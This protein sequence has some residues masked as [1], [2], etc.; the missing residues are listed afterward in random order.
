VPENDQDRSKRFLCNN[1]LYINEKVVL[2]V[3]FFTRIT[4]GC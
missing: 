4:V 3:R 1:L 2:T